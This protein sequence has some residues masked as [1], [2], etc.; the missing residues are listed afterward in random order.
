M[1]FT[2]QN[3]EFASTS[4]YIS[5]PCNALYRS[6]EVHSNQTTKLP[7]TTSVGKE[8]VNQE[9]QLNREKG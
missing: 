7:Y 4:M 6:I 5:E 8:V 1:K 9:Q 3:L 2:E